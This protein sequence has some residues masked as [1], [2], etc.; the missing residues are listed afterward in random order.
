MK[1][2]RSKGIIADTPAPLIEKVNVA[3]IL[4][5]IRRINEYCIFRLPCLKS[6]ILYVISLRDQEDEFSLTY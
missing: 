6:K 5:L 3:E 1:R 2:V 4:F